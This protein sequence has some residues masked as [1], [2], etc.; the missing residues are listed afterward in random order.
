MSCVMEPPL[1]SVV[2]P[3]YNQ[4]QFLG[5]AIQSVLEQRYQNLEIIVVNDASTDNTPQV[6][7][8]FKDSRLKYITHSQN[9][10]L[11]AARNTGMRASKGEIIALLDSDDIFPP[12]KLQV[13]VDFL[14]EHPEIG[15]TYNPRFNLNHSAESI[16]DL[17]RPPKTVG[18]NDFIQGFPFS[19]SDMVIR[20]EWAFKVGLFDAGYRSGG[21][22]LDFPCRL[23]LAG[24]QFA[25]VDRALNYRRFHAGRRKKNLANRLNDYENALNRVFNTPN[26]PAE[27]LPLRDTAFANY[28]L[29]VAYLALAQTERELG[30]KTLRRAVQLKPSL[31]RGNPSPLMKFFLANSIADENEDHQKILHTVLAQLP[32]EIKGLNEQYNWAAGRGYL[33]KG[34]RA[35]LWDRPE[36]GRA[37]FKQAAAQKAL[38]DESFLQYLAAQLNSY[39]LEFGPA[40]TAEKLRAL[41][42]QLKAVGYRAAA[43]K[44]SGIYLINRA[45]KNYQSGNYRQV[46]GSVWAAVAQQ[47]S[48][49]ANRGALSILVRSVWQRIG[50]ES[51]PEGFPEPDL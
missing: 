40:A 48:Y 17:W 23:A 32:P 6:A 5:Q 13:N 36:A 51:R 42:A 34:A 14:R 50:P 15:V 41:S 28:T 47:P 30:Q 1:V 27:T 35:I 9:R 7:A 37:H 38:P 3:A 16:R 26:C 24:C 4:A 10:G 11:P 29:E 25:G 8:Q 19:P 31:R 20:R 45:F 44:L 39:Q 2:I 33:L 22:D 18:L 46:P 21:E 12:D 43:R 49:L